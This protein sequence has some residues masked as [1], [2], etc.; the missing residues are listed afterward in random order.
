MARI[1]REIVWTITR[2]S[3]GRIKLTA[4]SG[5]QNI[6]TKLDHEVYT[7]ERDL[8]EMMCRL[9]DKYNNDPSGCIGVSF[10]IG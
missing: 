1:N 8:M 9:A 3:R 6:D 4:T 2:E 10:E 7:S 5:T